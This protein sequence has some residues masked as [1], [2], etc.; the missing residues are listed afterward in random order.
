M[1]T[2]AMVAMAMA[3][4]ERKDIDSIYF[5]KIAEQSEAHIF[6]LPLHCALG[7]LLFRLGVFSQWAR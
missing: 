2:M 4:T 3:V 1:D 5:G 7:S 6:S